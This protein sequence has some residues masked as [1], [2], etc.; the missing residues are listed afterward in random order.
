M[1]DKQKARFEKLLQTFRAEAADH[2]QTINRAL[3]EV[4]RDPDGVDRAEHLQSAYRAAHNVKGAARMVGLDETETLSHALESV[5]QAVIDKRLALDAD[6]CDVLYDTLDIIARHIEGEL[7]D[8]TATQTQLMTLIVDETS[9][10]GSNNG[11]ANDVVEPDAAIAQLEDAIRTEEFSQNTRREILSED[12]IRVSISKLDDLIAQISELQVSQ[13][14]ADQRLRDLRQFHSQFH[15]WSRSWDEVS[16]SIIRHSTQNGHMRE[17]LER[18]SDQIQELLYTADTVVQSFSRDTLRLGLVTDELRDRVRDIRMLPFHS[19]SLGFERAVRDA[20][21]V[22]NKQVAFRIE[23]EETELDKKV[24]ELL[25]DPLM[26]LLRNA[27]SHG[28]ET[29][30]IRQEAGKAAEGQIVLRVQQKGNEVSIAVCDDGRGFDLDALRLAA[31]D[32]NVDLSTSDE[33]IIQLAFRP[34][35]TTATRISSV[36][37]RGV[38]LDVV[39]DQLE[40]IHG[41]IHVENNPG[42]GATIEMIVPTSLAITRALLVGLS[43]QQFAIPLLAIEKIIEVQRTVDVNG[44]HMVLVDKVHIPIVALSSVLEIENN[45]RPEHLTP[46]ALVLQ[47]ADYRLAILVDTVLTEQELSVK[48]M[49]Y[50]LQHVPH[51]TGAAMLSNGM[52]IVVLNPS[53]ILRTARHGKRSTAVGIKTAET[54]QEVQMVRV[55]VVDDS[56]TTRT[57]EQNILEAAG[58][59][60]KTATNGLEALKLLEQHPFDIIISDV[61]M[62]QMDG[63]G[64]TETIRKDNRFNQLPIILVTSL[65]KREDKERGML[66]G[67]DAYI[68]KRGFNQ[69]EL[70]TT[71]RR[72]TQ[73]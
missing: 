23:G 11:D 47:I 39:R 63:F 33:E 42:H 12:T 4:E 13:M 30:A 59:D 45:S 26:H 58:Y 69:A 73:E 61:Q 51:V 66:S 64:L 71:I 8:V 41:R 57:L 9:P 3:L 60:V 34:G 7:I 5:I 27:V 72:F 53:D 24:L 50:L 19:I 6:T 70:L 55:L 35:V 22:E 29:P 15:R 17:V 62:P 37:G 14:N 2:I 49:G 43:E 56:I 68:V 21:H 40:N 25:K 36:S 32:G 1:T 48:P 67:A 28:I 16:T 46:R 31:H 65:E 52:P 20:A 10:E 38:G 18:Q 44:T 54:Q